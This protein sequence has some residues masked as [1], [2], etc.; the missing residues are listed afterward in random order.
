[1]MEVS[2]TSLPVID[3]SEL[4]LVRSYMT[5][6]CFGLFLDK[7]L[8]QISNHI[9]KLG[10]RPEDSRRLGELAHSMIGSAGVIG[11]SKVEA[12]ARRL[13]KLSAADD[14]SRVG[15]VSAKLIA[16]WIEVRNELCN[17]RDSELDH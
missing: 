2:T 1:M 6:V 11:A 15:D 5:R 14:K 10:S 12:I 7:C 17:W 16:A 3:R 8:D 13:E 9:D 4:G